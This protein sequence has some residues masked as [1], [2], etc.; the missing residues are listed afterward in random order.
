M[1]TRKIL[2]GL[3]ALL[4]LLSSVAGCTTAPSDET[5]GQE[6]G[7]PTDLKVII[8]GDS[9][10]EEPWNS[11]YIA[12][13][14]RVAAQKPHDLNITYEYADN[15]QTTDVERVMREYAQTGEYNILVFHAGAFRDAAE[16]IR[17]EYP[18]LL[19]GANGS[20]YEALGGNFFY[21]NIY[22]HECAYLLGMVAGMMTETNK[23]GAVGGFPYPNVNLPINAFFAGAKSVNSDVEQVVSYIESWY[24]PAKA[25]ESAAAQIAAG[26]DFIYAERFGPFEAAKEAGVYAFGHYSDQHELSPEVVVSSAVARWDPSVAK[27]VDMWWE[28]EANDVPYNAPKEVY[29]STLAEGVCEV[30]PYYS[31]DSMI[32]QYVKDAVEQVKADI[33][34]GD[35]VVPFND[36]PAESD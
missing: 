26:A 35:A 9:P 23:V 36:A 5:G 1:N 29:T 8:A 31:F 33:I 22:I 27:L 21:S 4:V 30:A 14:E 13:W 18:D 12:A 20:N 11:I 6:G 34:S 3:F 2:Y 24:D 16:K 15:V 32:P 19:I 17:E 28:H 7:A 10:L 25:K